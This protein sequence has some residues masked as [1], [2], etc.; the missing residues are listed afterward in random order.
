[1]L[2]LLSILA[3]IA[4]FVASILAS[5]ISGEVSSFSKSSIFEKKALP[6]TGWEQDDSVV[7]DKDSMFMKLRIHLVQQNMPDFHD[8]AM[9][10]YMRFRSI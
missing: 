3:V 6:P 10:V 8:L 4:A 2:F 9:K 5:P 7:L 1:M